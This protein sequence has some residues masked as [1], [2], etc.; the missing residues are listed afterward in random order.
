MQLYLQALALAKETTLSPDEFSLKF[1]GKLGPELLRQVA[2]QIHYQKILQHK[3]PSWGENT[4]APPSLNIEQSSSESTA[5]F[6]ASLLNGN[7]GIDLSGG[8]GVDS[9]FLSENCE[10]FIHNEPNTE[11]SKIVQYNFSILGRKNVKFTQKKAEELPLEEADFI[12]LD[13]SRRDA[14]L[15]KVFLPEDCSPNLPQLRERLLQFTPVILV[16]YAPM[17]DIKK[18]IKDLETVSEIWVLADKNEVKELIFKIERKVTSAPLIHAVNLGQS[19]FT[20]TFEEESNA[21][22]PYAR[23]KKY[24]YEPN[25]AIMKSGAFQTVA[26]KYNLGKLAK[27]SHLYTSDEYISD[28]PGRVLE[29]EEVTNFD[30]KRLKNRFS[31]QKVH[32]I[33]RNF[34]EKPEEIKKK[35]GW[36]DGGE[37][38]VYF[39]TLENLQKTCIITKKVSQ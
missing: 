29:I 39:T 17:L 10:L 26:M 27:N 4:I 34:P 33:V 21:A 31:N 38:F 7:K 32:V 2:R 19:P 13:P 14:D 23:P 22:I 36:K 24:L 5:K 6:K 35:M 12:Y 28:F 3:V 9:Y 20:F 15:K 30:K 16:K 11:L 25:A 37:H 8:M 1:S 18:A